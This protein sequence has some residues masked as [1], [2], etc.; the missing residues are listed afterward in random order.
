MLREIEAIDLAGEGLA[1]VFVHRIGLGPAFHRHGPPREDGI[2]FQTN[3]R[4]DGA[5]REFM[6]DDRAEAPAVI[7]VH[8]RRCSRVERRPRWTVDEKFLPAFLHSS[9][10]ELH[11]RVFGVAPEVA[12]VQSE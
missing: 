7:N 11:Q 9:Q 8:R 6:R 12:V 1:G 4:D 10:A 2:R 3:P 5:T